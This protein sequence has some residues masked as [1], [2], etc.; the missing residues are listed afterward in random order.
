MG[1]DPI[2]PEDLLRHELDALRETGVVIPELQ[3]SAQEQLRSLEQLMVYETDDEPSHPARILETIGDIEEYAV[4]PDDLGQRILGGWLG[5]CAA[6]TLGKPFETEA[7]TPQ[8]IRG[9]LE[10]ADAWP[11]DDYVP[12]LDPMPTRFQLRADCAGT[13]TRGNIRFVTRDDDLDYT[14]LNLLLLEQYGSEFSVDD[15]ARTWLQL[16]PFGKMFTA[17]AVAYRNVCLGLH[18]PSTATSSNPYCQWVGALIRA[19]VF[20]LVSPGRPRDAA[21]MAMTD[22]SLSHTRNGIYGEMWAAAAVANAFT[23]STVAQVVERSLAVVPPRSTLHATLSR[24][25]RMYCDGGSWED[26]VAWIHQRGLYYVHVLNNAAI[27]AAALLWSDGDFTRAAG[28]AVSSALDTDSNAATVGAV[29][30]VFVGAKG[31]PSHWVDPLQDS[32]RSALSG[33]AEE[34]IIGLA[35]RTEH[36]ALRHLEIGTR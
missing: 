13:T 28:L 8:T 34:S 3:G 14:L 4:E 2:S 6:N 19:D 22:A 16:L 10:F 35:R 25:L 23:A 1:H 31:I 7:W 30:G 36:L 26:A 11:L 17:E 20:G 32:F 15:V 29:M 5:R 21:R 33:Y 9:Y 12:M 18:A 24:I 27:I